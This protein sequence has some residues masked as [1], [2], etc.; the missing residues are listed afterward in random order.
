MQ[1][2][3]FSEAD[4][5]M[6]LMGN[7][8]RLAGGFAGAGFGRC[9]GEEIG[10]ICRRFQCRASCRRM[11]GKGREMVLHRLELGDGSAALATLA[12]ILHSEA[13]YF[14]KGAGDLRHAEKRRLLLHRRVRD[15]LGGLNSR[16][17]IQANLVT[18]LAGENL[19]ARYLCARRLAKREGIVVANDGHVRRMACPGHMARAA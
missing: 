15:A 5:A 2:R 16:H 8:C 6:H 17:A 12:G 3:F 14:F 4:G 1:G 9:D 11:S 19:S 18:R 7:G 13:K 10:R